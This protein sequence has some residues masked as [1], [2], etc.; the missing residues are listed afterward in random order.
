MHR[1]SFIYQATLAGLATQLPSVTSADTPHSAFTRASTAEEVTAGLNLSGKTAVVTGC[2][3]GIGFETMRVLALRGAHVIGTAR[4]IEKGRE[5]C[6][7][8]KGKATPVV[9]ELTDFASVVA[10]ANA[11]RAVTTKIDMLILNAG[12]ILPDWQQVNGLEKQFVVNHLG[13][14]LLTHHFVDRVTA[15]E[16]GRVVVVGSGNHRQ[17]PDGGIQFDDLSGKGWYNKGYHHSKLANGLFSLELSRRLLKTRATS[18]CLSPGPVET[19]IRRD[20]PANSA[21]PNLK[22]TAQ[23]A[24]TVCYV[25]AHLSLKFVTG[26]YFSDCNPAPQSPYQT[27]RVMAAKLW[28]V[29]TQLTRNYLRQG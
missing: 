8:V 17:A 2:N 20:M 28:E 24:A 19:N 22:T 15:V 10:C 4:T 11:I 6:S 3:S 18:N 9:L 27:D 29:S 12:I 13:H 1:R 5:A 23:G 16:Q 14:F 7:Q 25:A 26:E 21:P